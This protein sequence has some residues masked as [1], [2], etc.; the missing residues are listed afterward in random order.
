MENNKWYFTATAIIFTVVCLA[1]LTIILWNV[2][3]V[4]AN[5]SIPKWMNGVAV[6]VA[7]YLA[8]RGFM[9]AHKL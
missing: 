5:Y 1:H 4:V 3:A 7:G 8:A 2:E 6:I 9:E